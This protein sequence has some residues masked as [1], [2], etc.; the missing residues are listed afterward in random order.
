MTQSDTPVPGATGIFET[1]LVPPRREVPQHIFQASYVRLQKASLI[2]ATAAAVSGFASIARSLL[3]WLWPSCA[4]TVEVVF[5]LMIIAV[6]A[7]PSAQ[8]ST[9]PA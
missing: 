7:P 3:A 5:T 2:A 4:G 8:F 6:G 9:E 1:T